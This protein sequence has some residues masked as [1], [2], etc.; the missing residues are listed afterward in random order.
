MLLR[1]KI[2][3][4]LDRPCLTP[5]CTSLSLAFL[6]FC[7]RFSRTQHNIFLA[8]IKRVIRGVATQIVDWGNGGGGGGGGGSFELGPF[9][10]RNYD[11]GDIK[12]SNVSS[13]C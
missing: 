12:E 3:S 7:N 4:L 11:E 2:Y 13:S 5:A 10:Y 8:I 9:L 1:A 6:F